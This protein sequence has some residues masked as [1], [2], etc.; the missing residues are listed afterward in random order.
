M[1]PRY[2]DDIDEIVKGM[3]DREFTARQ[4]TDTLFRMRDGEKHLPTSRKVGEYLRTNP[5]VDKVS[6]ERD[7]NHYTFN[8]EWANSTATS[9][10]DTPTFEVTSSHGTIPEVTT[11]LQEAIKKVQECEHD[12]VYI[13]EHE[14]CPHCDGVR[15]YG[16]PLEGLDALKELAREYA[17]N[18]LA[19]VNN[20]ELCNLY[21]AYLRSS[22]MRDGGTEKGK[23][24]ALKD[25]LLA[26]ACAEI[27]I[28]HAKKQRKIIRRMR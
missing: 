4:V 18:A 25:T 5:M 17:P 6:R 22:A 16:D 1:D 28:L 21:Q 7:G 27:L 26:Q 20:M 15:E 13:E 19:S 9:T 11:D 10:D 12:W 8:P 2:E 14:Q 3:G 24:A 23:A